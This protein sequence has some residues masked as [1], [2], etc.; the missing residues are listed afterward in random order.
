MSVLDREPEPDRR[1]PAQVAVPVV[2]LHGQPGLG[3]DFAPVARILEPSFKVLSVD[4]PGYGSTGG[5][6]ISMTDNANFFASHIERSATERVVL[7]GHSYGGG[8]AILLAARR[9]DLVRGLVLVA[10]VGSAAHIGPID[11]V[12]AA[13]V[14]GDVLVA[15]FVT[16]ARRVLPLVRDS[17]RR[18]PGALGRWVAGSLPDRSFAR[19][20]EFDAQSVRKSVVAEQRALLSEIRDVES[21]LGEL[22]LPVEVISGTWD[23]IVPPAASRAIAS[24][25]PGAVI[26]LVPGIGHFVPRDAPRAVASAVE[27]VRERSALSPI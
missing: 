19:T 8:I 11:H 14:I 23:M 17:G 22:D 10:S 2:F 21:A 24:R 7:V 6:A 20:A 18:I 13:P 1:S 4:R 3:R 12:L 15:G 26:E 9:P 25:V 27:R 16:S 5:A